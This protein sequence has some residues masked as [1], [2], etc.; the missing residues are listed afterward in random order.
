VVC[1]GGKEDSFGFSRKGLGS[2]QNTLYIFLSKYF[3]LISRNLISSINWGWTPF[4]TTHTHTH[5][6]RHASQ[7]W[8]YKNK[9]FTLRKIRW[10][11]KG[12][13]KLNTKP[14]VSV[15]SW[16]WWGSE[17]LHVLEP[18][19]RSMGYLAYLVRSLSFIRFEWSALYMHLLWEIFFKK[20][21]KIIF[22]Q[23]PLLHT[24]LKKRNS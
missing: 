7:I 9:C 21:R 22:N 1:G 13:V 10:Q 23:S 24:L 19:L 8:F 3:Y 16:P 6:H 18:G 11:V 5:T 2:S 17:D 4:L 15:Q 12:D 14:E 20:A